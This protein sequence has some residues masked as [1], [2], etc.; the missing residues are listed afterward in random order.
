MFLGHVGV[1]FALKR[2]EPK[3][4]LATLIATALAMD[5]VFSILLLFGI[6]HV[7]ISPGATVMSPFEFY[8]YP[9]SHSLL[10]SLVMAMFVF[11]LTR[12]WSATFSTYASFILAVSVFS[13]F[14]LDLIS[15]TPDLPLI[16][17]DTV[18][19]GFSLWNSMLGTLVVEFGLLFA[20]V[21]FY[22]SATNSTSSIGK[23]GLFLIILLLVLVFISGLVEP[24]P[25]TP[26]SLAM[27]IIIGLMLII[28]LSYWIDRHRAVKRP[29][30]G[31]G[32]KT[33]TGTGT[34]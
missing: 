12:L 14:M 31:T 32:I 30:R 25:S 22:L 24:P 4:S 27:S 20:G 15:H 21:V 9:Y 1:G 13:H 29:G 10:G 5:F 23:H 18:K 33:G 17:N 7:I 2:A 3:L 28:S 8:D 19:L 11:L 34:V 16:G 26:T 6:E